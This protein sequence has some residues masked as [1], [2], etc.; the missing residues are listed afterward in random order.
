[1]KTKNTRELELSRAQEA[2]MSKHHK[3]MHN[4][5]SHKD[6]R[7]SLPLRSNE[8]VRSAEEIPSEQAG[9]INEEEYQLGIERETAPERRPQAERSPNRE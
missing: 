3:K 9:A 7:K 2:T 6:A 1:M 8:D 5:N 4:L